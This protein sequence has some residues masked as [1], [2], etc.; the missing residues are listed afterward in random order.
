MVPSTGDGLILSAPLSPADVSSIAATRKR[1]EVE[2]VFMSV[3]SGG[4]LSKYRVSVNVVSLPARRRQARAG[5]A[6]RLAGI[7][8]RN[9]RQQRHH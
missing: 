4:D 8:L 7:G 6:L 9:R 5:Y 3:A 2:R 1:E